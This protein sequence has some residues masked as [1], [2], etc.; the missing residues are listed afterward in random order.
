MSQI[1]STSTEEVPQ[2]RLSALEAT[3][4]EDHARF[5]Q[6][7]K[8]SEKR[9]KW[10][11]RLRLALVVGLVFSYFFYQLYYFFSHRLNRVEYTINSNV[12]EMPTPYF[13]INH[14]SG[15]F[16]A[17]NV[18]VYPGSSSTFSYFDVIQVDAKNIDD[19][20]DNILD[21]D[22]WLLIKNDQYLLNYYTQWLVIP[23]VNSTIPVANAVN[24]IPL[25]VCCV[26]L[27]YCNYFCV[28]YFAC[29]RIAKLIKA[30]KKR[31]TDWKICLEQC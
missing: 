30:K 13:Y 6:L 31:K 27:N 22:Q 26:I 1:G 19:I 9:K 17:C 24:R 18:S 3:T 28:Q 23:P 5:T 16:S 8:K 12:D 15:N 11:L 4:H 21:Y 10:I 20:T 14:E 2:K 29:I 25:E 7:F